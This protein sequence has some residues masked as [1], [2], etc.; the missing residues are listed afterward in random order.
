MQPAID[1]PEPIRTPRLELVSMSVPF[2]QALARRDLDTATELLDA[3]VDRWLAE[4]LADFVEY[5]LRQLADDPTIRQWLGRAMVLTDA[6]G[7]RRVIGSIGFHGPPD[8]LGR[9][10]VGYSVE[11]E[12]RRRG[13]AREAIEALFDWAYQRHGITTFIASIRPDNVASLQLAAG[14]GFRQVGEQIDEIDGLELVFETT[15]PAAGRRTS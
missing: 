10:E 5:R 13:L 2:M 6:A 11:P 7:G 3:T 4:Q 9:L 8:D 14:F 1:D 15:W 12:H